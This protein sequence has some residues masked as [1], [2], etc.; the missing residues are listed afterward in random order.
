[1]NKKIYFEDPEIERRVAIMKKHPPEEFKAMETFRDILKEC[2]S[3]L[4]PPEEE[5]GK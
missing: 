4:F 5:V 1:M 3:H 2:A